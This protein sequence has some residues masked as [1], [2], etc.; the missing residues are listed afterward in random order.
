MYFTGNKYY[1]PKCKTSFILSD[2]QEAAREDILYCPRCGQKAAKFTS[3]FWFVQK[4][5]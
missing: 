1:C 4:Q 2:K 5:T 3:A